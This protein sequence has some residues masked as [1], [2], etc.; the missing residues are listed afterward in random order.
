M[1]TGLVFLTLGLYLTVS[2]L[3]LPSEAG[4]FP[5]V[6]GV[7]MVLLALA[8]LRDR[9]PA[10]SIENGRTIAATL[11]LTVLYLLLWGTGGFALKTALYLLA[12]LRLYG[13]PWRPAAGAALFLT[14]LVTLGFQ[15]GLRLTLE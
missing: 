11:A 7:L 4:M 12:L 1:I 13:Q 8:A 2:S 6:L 9:R 14:A 15:L 10:G 5:R 3:R